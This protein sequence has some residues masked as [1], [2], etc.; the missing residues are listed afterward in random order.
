GPSFTEDPHPQ[1]PACFLD[2][3][4]V[5]DLVKEFQQQKGLRC[6]DDPE[7]EPN[8]LP[9]GAGAE[10]APAVEGPVPP[11]PGEGPETE[12][13]AGSVVV[14]AEPPDR[15]PPRSPEARGECAWPPER[16]NRSCV[17]SL[18]KSRAFGKMVAA[19]VYARGFLQAQARAFLG[20]GLAYNW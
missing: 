17:A 18:A 4:Q 3:D 14:P 19:E 10:P 16:T 8:E 12:G 7:E 1:P 15:R 11:P 9:S 13:V 5:Q 20:D 2:R 6:Y